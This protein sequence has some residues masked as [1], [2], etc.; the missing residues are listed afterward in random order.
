MH[1]LA[2]IG[3]LGLAAVAAPARADE[4]AVGS[5]SDPE[6]ELEMDPEP[7]RAPRPAPPPP[8]EEPEPEPAGE[9]GLGPISGDVFT[10][11]R[12]PFEGDAFQQ[13]SASAWLRARPRLT[14]ATSAALELAVDGIER[15][16]LTGAR[17]RAALREAYVSV[18]KGGW[19]LRAGRQIIPWGGSDVVNPT[20]F[21]SA[22]DLTFFVVEPERTRTGAT[23]VLLSRAWS[24]AEA[25]LVA[26]PVHP[27]SVLIVP[28]GALPDGTTLAAPA[29]RSFALADTEVAAKLKLSGRGWD[30]AAVGFRGFN[31][32]PEFE[33]VSAD[34]DGV[35]VRQTHHRY[36]AAGL[37][38]SVALGKLVVRFEGAFVQTENP[39][40]EDPT[41][42]PSYLFGVLGVERPLGE[43][44]RVQAQVMA[45]TYPTWGAPEDTTGPDPITAGARRGV[46]RANALLLDYQEALRPAL[47]ARVAYLSAG[48]RLAAEVFGA[49]NTMGSDYL[50]RPLVGWRPSEA[51][52]VQVGAEIYGGHPSRPLGALHPFGGVFSQVS[53]TF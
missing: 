26:T 11:V 12:V 42:Q 53:F 13:V 51:V 39:L 52:A 10:Y 16:E 49:I 33:L 18:R 24:R 48:E 25:T 15:S 35:V 20:D 34:A 19:L 5:G 8:P 21:L 32:T 17:L 3:A 50:V 7:A 45:R 47:T 36:L 37:D 46:A 23:S 41:I 22:R 27:A 44:V 38:G 1:R 4:P 2:I 28:P 30:L 31:H 6:P 43:R 9:G 29:P 14:E 40:G